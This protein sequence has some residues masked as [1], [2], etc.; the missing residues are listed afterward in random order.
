M[1]SNPQTVPIVMSMG[2]LKRFKNFGFNTSKT[3]DVLTFTNPD[4]S[5]EY[6]ALHFDLKENFI[7]RE[8]HFNKN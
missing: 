7:S 8:D 6:V 4:D 5:N 2:A 3:G 1:I